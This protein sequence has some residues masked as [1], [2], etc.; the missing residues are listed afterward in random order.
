M[1]EKRFNVGFY[2]GDCIEEGGEYQN[3]A[4]LFSSLHQQM[5]QD[6]NY[7]P[8]LDKGNDVYQ[9]RDLIR[10]NNGNTYKGY[11][12]KFR[13]N[14]LPHIA[15]EFRRVEQDIV[16]DDT[17]GLIEKNYFLFDSRYKLLVIQVN[18]NGLTVKAIGEL[19]TE[20]INKTVVLNPVLTQDAAQ[21]IINNQHQPKKYEL[22]FSV[23][24]NPDLFP[25]DAWS[26]G[27][28]NMLTQ[29]GGQ[30]CNIMVNAN[31]IGQRNGRLTDH[32]KN[33]ITEFSDTDIT[34]RLAKIWFEDNSDPID[35]IADRIKAKTSPI[36]MHGRYPDANELYLELARIKREREEE[37]RQVLFEG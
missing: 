8:S 36:V 10:P 2:T 12:A 19:L 23:P 1:T 11:F 7:F 14:D 16:L 6:E 35:L 34:V 15:E 5:Q 18:S 9:I 32:L 17:Q 24:Q 27:L 4:N 21:R 29:Q 22:G 37:I 28:L 26:S 20:L 31:A 3:T 25:A 30:S 13:K 33:W